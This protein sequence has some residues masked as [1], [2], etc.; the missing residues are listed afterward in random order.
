VKLPSVLPPADL[1]EQTDGIARG[2]RQYHRL[3]RLGWIAGVL[4]F[5]IGI[6]NAAAP[7]IDG[8]VK[9]LPPVLRQP[10]ESLL[11]SAYFQLLIYGLLLVTAAV[12]LGAWWISLRL[13]EARQPFHY[14]CSIGE[15][16]P[17]PTTDKEEKLAWLT[18]DLGERLSERVRRLRFV[19][20][21]GARGKPGSADVADAD[22]PH[23]HVQGSYVIRQN[24]QEDRWVVEVSPRV[25]IGR[26]DAPATLAHKVVF[27]LDNADP[28]SPGPAAPSLA[29][30]PIAA[31]ASR[32]A[33]SKAT[34]ST[35]APRPH[36]PLTRAGYERLLE[37]VYFSVATEVYR[38]IQIDVQQKIDLL[39][40]SYTQAVAL[41]HEAEDY[42][43]SQTLDG[44]ENAGRLYERAVKL[45][46][47][48]LR[49]IPRFIGWRYLS[50]LRRWLATLGQRLALTLAH[51]VPGLAHGELL[52]IRSQIGYA[53]MLV[54][55]HS[56]A[57]ISGQR[58]NAAFEAVPVARRALDRI[59]RVPE[60]VPGRNA[61]LF[62]AY[63]T[64][65]LALTLVEAAPRAGRAG[66]GPGAR[67]YPRRQRA[68]L[69]LRPRL[70]R[71]E[72]I[73]QF[74]LS[75]PGGRPRASVRRR[76]LSLCFCRRAG[77]APAPGSR[78]DRGRSGAPGL[79]RGRRGQ[80][81]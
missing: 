80:P 6:A 4:F 64:Y 15:F 75:A 24:R 35:S 50:L 32:K 65:A 63:V 12:S 33:R 58:V 42:A 2:L 34:A 8:F 46:D 31:D 19:E 3:G 23:L 54:Y 13:Q 38:Q 47:V 18:Q 36:R 57:Q 68:N 44:Y 37:R 81:G 70:G 17:G 41:F 53:R 26:P 55:R 40:T 51:A 74:R 59:R 49:P 45:F 10:L 29:D 79:R 48:R 16:T 77:V 27:F 22:Q 78:C 76:Q 71:G 9:Q 67:S 21:A 60:V 62:D 73:D 20:S 5:A 1:L 39:P 43:G 30:A 66:A 56:L 61:A 7:A 52:C 69:P 11:P 14:T 28:S 25:R 72:P